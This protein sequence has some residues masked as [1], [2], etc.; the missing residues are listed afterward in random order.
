MSFG[1]DMPFSEELLHLQSEV[2]ILLNRETCPHYFKKTSYERYFRSRNFA[3][4]W[5]SFRMVG[6]AVLCIVCGVV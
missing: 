4:D 1:S 5:C 2:S 6:G 3:I